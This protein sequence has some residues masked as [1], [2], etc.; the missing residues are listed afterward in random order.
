TL[1]RSNR[2]ARVTRPAGPSNGYS[3]SIRTMGRLR[4]R[5]FSAS[6]ARVSSFSS[7]SNSFRRASHS[8]LEATRGLSWRRL[9]DMTAL[10]VALV[11]DTGRTG[12]PDSDSRLR[13]VREGQL[14]AREECPDRTDFEH[15]A[16][17][18]E[19]VRDFGRLVR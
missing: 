8:S 2:S 5:A 15:A 7:A 19:R 3:L 1:F 11:T 17:D 12:P 9:S 4:R 16:Q 13:L 6:R 10:P 18:R 14:A